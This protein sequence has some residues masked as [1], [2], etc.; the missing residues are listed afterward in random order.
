M[1]TD[2]GSL[3]LPIIVLVVVEL[4]SVA[5]EVSLEEAVVNQY[6]PLIFQKENI[7]LPNLGR[8]NFIHG[9]NASLLIF[10]VYIL[11]ANSFRLAIISSLI[12]FIVWVALPMLE[13]DEY[14][15]ILAER[16]SIR[17]V[18]WHIA[19]GII[20]IPYTVIYQQ[21]LGNVT[22]FGI[23]WSEPLLVGLFTS[24]VAIL[25]V[26]IETELENTYMAE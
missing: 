12:L 24:S 9:M 10:G 15:D 18:H 3:T 4:S 6:P 19:S 20:V 8:F 5:R 21:F 1:A 13:I 2:I 17:S 22:Y 7:L 25:L 26:K 11:S 23:E 16:E 14:D